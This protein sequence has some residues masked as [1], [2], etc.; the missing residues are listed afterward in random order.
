MHSQNLELHFFLPMTNAH[1]CSNLLSQGPNT[2][3]LKRLRSILQNERFSYAYRNNPNARSYSDVVYEPPTIRCEIDASY[4]DCEVVRDGAGAC[5][6]GIRC[7]TNKDAKARAVS[8]CKK[9]SGFGKPTPMSVTRLDADLSSVFRFKFETLEQAENFVQQAAEL[10]GRMPAYPPALLDTPADAPRGY[11]A[12]CLTNLAAKG[13]CLWNELQ[14]TTYVNDTV[15]R[16]VLA[17]VVDHDC[18]R[19]L[20]DISSILAALLEITSQLSHDAAALKASWRLFIVRAFLWT[21]W[22]RCQLIYF[23]L[24]ARSAVLEGSPDNKKGDLFLRDTFPSP[25][26]TLHEMSR[27]TSS[28][29]KPKYM[30]GWNFELLRSNTVCIGADF[31]MFH[32]IY[33]SIFGSREARCLLGKAEACQGD[34]FKSCQRFQGMAIEAQSAHNQGCPKDCRRLFWNEDSYRS[35]SGARAVSLK[36]VGC[37]HHG[38]LHYCNASANTLAI[39]HVWSQ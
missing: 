21:T 14:V 16:I 5:G 27:L 13:N 4:F 24:A 26:T 8:I 29:G 25:D 33:S 37:Y 32:Q 1:A 31:R 18:R 12:S 20:L 36:H 22:Q 23:H 6:E 15:L 19:S 7:F 17:A 10:L 11:R 30:C 38:T 39:S 3:T 2:F 34:S 28:I 9:L 35:T